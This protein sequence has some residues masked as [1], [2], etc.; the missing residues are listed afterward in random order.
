MERNQESFLFEDRCTP[1]FRSVCFTTKHKTHKIYFYICRTIF[2]KSFRTFLTTASPTAVRM[3]PYRNRAFLWK[4]HFSNRYIVQT[5]FPSFVRVLHSGTEKIF[6]NERKDG[7]MKEYFGIFPSRHTPTTICRIVVKCL[8][9]CLF[10][11]SFHLY[12]N[13]SWPCSTICH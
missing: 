1:F 4:H 8:L 3:R 11:S 10:C 13:K 6:K 12:R 7:W 2:L 9:T 5:E